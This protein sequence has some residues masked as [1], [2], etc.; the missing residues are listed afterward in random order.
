MDMIILDF[1]V[2]F[3]GL[4]ESVAKLP[5]NDPRRVAVQMVLNKRLKRIVT[6]HVSVYRFS[7]LSCDSKS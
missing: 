5:R 1:K 4:D 3:D 2:I 7:S 6:W